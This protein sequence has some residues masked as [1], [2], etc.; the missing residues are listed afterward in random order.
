MSEKTRTINRRG[1]K[2]IDN[3]AEILMG[4]RTENSSGGFLGA[5]APQYTF[6][7]Y[8]DRKRIVLNKTCVAY[9]EP[10]IEDVNS[11]W[12]HYCSQIHLKNCLETS[13][14]TAKEFAKELCKR[15]V[16]QYKIINGQRTRHTTLER[17]SCEKLPIEA[18]QTFRR[19]LNKQLKMGKKKLKAP[20]P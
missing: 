11:D 16:E 19:M 17:V 15:G 7:L 4:Y 8:I 18:Q 14:E 6:D 10:W 9:D 2:S 20:E 3:T 1:S 5:G 13:R 12:Y